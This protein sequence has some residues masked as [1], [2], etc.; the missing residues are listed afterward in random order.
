MKRTIVYI[1][2]TILALAA[3]SC[4]ATD[5][6]E[7]PT[8]EAHAP[9][10]TTE[11]TPTADVAAATATAEPEPTAPAATPTAEPAAFAL[12]PAVPRPAVALAMYGEA[13]LVTNPLSGESC[14]ATLDGGA[15]A[16]FQVGGDAVYWEVRSDAGTVVRRLGPDGQTVDLAFTARS[17]QE[18][19]GYYSFAVSADG[20]QIAWSAGR[21]GADQAQSVHEMWVANVDGS[22]VVSPLGE[23]RLSGNM[24]RA[25]APVRFSKDG[26]TLFYAWQPSG[27]GGIWSAFRGRYD[28]LY[29]LRLRTEAPPEQLFEC[30]EVDAF[31]CVGDFLEADG[32][33]TTLAYVDDGA[34]VVRNGLGETLNTHTP[35]GNY[36]AYPTFHEN[37]EMVFYAAELG[38]DGLLPQAAT[39]YRVAPPT[40]PAEA[41][42]TSPSLLPPQA[43]LDDT[44]VVIGFGHGDG[45]A[46]M[47]W[48]TAVLGLDG[49]LNIMQAE[50]NANFI[51]IMNESAAGGRY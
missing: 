39:I 21:P 1:L 5:V 28:S 27:V 12:C 44:R 15:P 17:R 50:P 32:Q 19:L 26:G 31:L 49:S 24:P 13:Y 18:A 6:T 37:G 11:P 25:L 35:E 10:P 47:N 2:I 48:G 34:V 38:D 42:A 45:V 36:V 33:V 30:A 29:A 23:Q 20:R 7:A 46:V 16:H 4:Q 8:V 51:A 43:W 41:L 14:E 3:A 40:A 22:D 9:T